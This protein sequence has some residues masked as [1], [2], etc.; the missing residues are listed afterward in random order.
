VGRVG[1]RRWSVAGLAGVV[2]SALSTG[3]DDPGGPSSPDPLRYE[4]TGAGEACR[5]VFGRLAPDGSAPLDQ[6]GQVDTPDGPTWVWR[7]S[8]V[9]DRGEPDLEV[10]G[11]DVHLSAESDVA[12]AVWELPPTEVGVA[13]RSL[14]EDELR[15][16]VPGFVTTADA[17]ALAEAVAAAIPGADVRYAGSVPPYDIAVVH[18]GTSLTVAGRGVAAEQRDAYY[19]ALGWVQSGDTWQGDVEGGPG[20]AQGATVTVGDPRSPATTTS[21]ASTELLERLMADGRVIVSPAAAGRQTPMGCAAAD[22]A[23][24]AATITDVAIVESD[25]GDLLDITV[26]GLAPPAGGD[27][28]AVRVSIGGVDLVGDLDGEVVRVPAALTHDESRLLADRL[29]G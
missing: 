5:V 15:T 9:V 25:V 16:L 2:V 29:R 8:A 24:G 6:V 19:G 1:V 11:I 4:L 18:D 7:G 26:E 28:Q 17:F 20:E 14:T 13:T 27:P 22:E 3:C 10:D 12:Q 23:D 21:A